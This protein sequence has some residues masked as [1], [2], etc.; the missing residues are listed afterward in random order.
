[1]AVI[2][3]KIKDLQNRLK[4]AWEILALASYEGRIKELE[5]QMNRPDFWQDQ[6][7][8][9][10]VSQ[11][12]ADLQ[13]ELDVWQALEQE[14]KDAVDIIE[15]A[16]SEG[17]QAAVDEVEKTIVQ[18]EDR[19]RQL[20]LNTM[21]SDQFDNNNAI[22]SIHAGAGGTDAMD[23]AGMLLRMY[24]RFVE[25]KGWQMLV[26]DES[27]REEA[28]YKSI[29][30]AVRGRR[31]YGH[32]R[33]EAGVHRL[34]RI[35]P[36]DAE[37]MRHTSFALVEVTPELDKITEKEL[38]LNP[39]DL[40][41]DTFAS[42]GAGG[43]SVNTTNSAVRVTHLPTNIVVTCQNERS[44]T[45]NKETALRVLKSRLFQ[46]MQEERAEKLEE[47]KGGHKSPEWGNQIRSY[48]LHPYKM[49]K[50]HRTNYETQDVELVLDGELEAFMEAYL[51]N[52]VQTD[53]EKST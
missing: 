20:E 15:L 38:A 43:Q 2:D 22:V 29:S 32:L 10:S 30:F 31:A 12:A 52:E 6:D 47:L 18:L 3:D 33:S 25:K 8:A 53:V 19:L 7:R 42:S 28:G 26:L 39:N 45:Q 13:S 16:Q 44:Q 11:E 50:D 46:R 21:F 17:D 34:V 4:T 51:K 35:S 37:K 48:V 36:F 41:I 9:K 5:E 14:L 23:W 49:V 1:M 27:P 40:R 24:A